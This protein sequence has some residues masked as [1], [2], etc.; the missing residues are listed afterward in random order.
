MANVSKQSIRIEISP[1]EYEG[2]GQALFEDTLY[3]AVNRLVP[4]EESQ[5]FLTQ[6]FFTMR[7]DETDN[8]TIAATV[9][10]SAKRAV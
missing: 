9:T 7:F 10:A 1:A 4:E 3:E 6:H 2:D 8:G 5:E